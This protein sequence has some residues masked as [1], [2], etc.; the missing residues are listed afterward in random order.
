MVMN[1]G[2]SG[3]PGPTQFSTA[4]YGGGS[5]SNPGYGTWVPPLTTACG[6]IPARWTISDAQAPSTS[7][8]SSADADPTFGTNTESMVACLEY[9]AD[10]FLAYGTTNRPHQDFIEFPNGTVD[11]VDVLTNTVEST[12]GAGAAF[13][14][15]VKTSTEVYVTSTVAG[16]V[17]IATT[18]GG[19][20]VE[21]WTGSTW[22][23]LVT[24]INTGSAYVVAY[25]SSGSSTATTFSQAA[26]VNTSF[27]GIASVVSAVA[28][29]ASTSGVTC[30]AFE[31]PYNEPDNDPNLTVAQMVAFKAACVSAYSGAVVLG[32]MPVTVDTA[33]LGW[34]EAF[35]TACTANGLDYVPNGLSFHMYNVVNGDMEMADQVLSAFRTALTNAGHGSVPLWM[36]EGDGTLPNNYGALSWRNMVHWTA[37]RTLMFEYYGIP[38]QRQATYY[39]TNVGYG[40][41]S[42]LITN[43]GNS[44][45]PAYHPTFSM[46]RGFIERTADATPPT[47]LTMPGAAAHL[48]FGSLYTTPSNVVAA[49]VTAGQPEGTVTLT[50]G[51]SVAATVYD[52]AGNTVTTSTGTVLDVG[53]SDLPTYVTVPSGTTVTVSDAD[54]GLGALTT[55]LATIST[56][57]SS[58][59]PATSTATGY[60]DIGAA[61]V[62]VNG[63]FECGF[64][65]NNGGG[66]S[67]FEYRSDVAPPVWFVLEWEAVQTVQRV[68][69]FSAPGWED[70][71]AP[72]QYNVYTWS[73]S[74]W[75]LRASYTNA[76]ASSEA[77]MTS[78]NTWQCFTEHFW[79]G[80][81]NFD[82]QFGP[83]TTNAVRVDVLGTS[84]GSDPDNAAGSPNA[85][86]SGPAVCL[87][88]IQVY[89]L[90]NSPPSAP[91]AVTA[92]A[93]VNEATVTWTPPV[94]VG[95]S[96][97]TGYT[98]T[99]TPGGATVA[100]GAAVSSAVVTG[101]TS[102]TT[103][104]FDVTATNAHGTSTNVP[105]AFPSRLRV[106]ANRLVD[107]NNVDV[108][109]LGGFNVEVAPTIPSAPNNPASPSNDY[110]TGDNFYWS[111]A[112]YEAMA[113]LGARLVRHTIF[114]DVFEPASL[115]TSTGSGDATHGVFDMGAVAALDAAIAN[116]AAAGMYTI[117]SLPHLLSGREPAW[118]VTAG[119][120][121]GNMLAD[122]QT[123]GQDLVA[124][125]AARYVN[126]PAVIGCDVNEPPTSNLATL[127]AFYQTYVPWWQVHAPLWPVWVSPGG[128]GSGTP[129]PASGTVANAATYLALDVNDRGVVCSWHDYLNSA[130][131]Y[132]V[133]QKAGTGNTGDI[134]PEDQSPGTFTAEFH[135][136]GDFWAYPDTTQTRTDFGT[137][138]APQ[139]TFAS[140]EPTFALAINEFGMDSMGGSTNEAA[141]VADKTVCYHAANPVTELWWVYDTTVVS[142][143]SAD[144]FS[145]RPSGTWRPSLVTWASTYPL[146]VAVPT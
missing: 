89:G 24:A 80:Q 47:R 72:L 112:D 69:L 1:D 11:V 15:L 85:G 77:F 87:R 63:E 116:A 93:G 20:A 70:Q 19:S 41:P 96:A 56:I 95:G 129:S 32:P 98:V 107:I 125:I 141:W 136:W 17:H 40:Y 14:M 124:F 28:A 144:P 65:I 115:N 18:S 54:S 127:M 42:W 128:Y 36:T 83:V 111:A 82:V 108:G 48:F 97:I 120:S 2:V 99:A 21:T 68:L 79:D 103:Y 33:M 26:I 94:S 7:P 142:S 134:A 126:N 75:V 81:H 92:V 38:I 117:L 66:G 59:G 37:L 114:W 101:L 90:D 139:I 91:L 73:G 84:Y 25:S 140:S 30:P 145:A 57:S 102:G 143:S 9:D 8:N 88:E 64:Y 121:S 4:G 132:G 146:N 131:T 3:L 55:N 45:V 122:F 104:T 100:V 52:W 135:G 16:T 13:T 58:V 78:E 6:T 106:A 60:S 76:T 67:Q 43:A 109:T 138:I 113:A 27:V 5:Y 105:A 44:R 51:S 110:T 50:F 10:W 71:D 34:I 23:A 74:A 12:L 133:Y 118:A 31:G 35:F 137:A 22:G 86:Q 130:G 29:Q 53:V 62:L 123:Y 49:L 39:M 61:T 46:W 119:G